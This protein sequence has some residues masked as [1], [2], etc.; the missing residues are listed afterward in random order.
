M[1][2]TQTDDNPGYDVEVPDGWQRLEPPPGIALLAIEGGD[3]VPLDAEASGFR[4]NLVVTMQPRVTGGV[5]TDGEVDDYLTTLLAT[6]DEQLHDVEELGVWVGDDNVTTPE[7]LATQRVL[8][9]YRIDHAG[10]DAPLEV[11]MMQQHIWLDDE[12]VTLT[13]TVPSG[14]DDRTIDTLNVCLESLTVSS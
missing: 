14:V 11:E 6:L 8:V 7:R 9:G 12:I 3:D 13:A 1:S 10:G 2:Q 5:P 4:S